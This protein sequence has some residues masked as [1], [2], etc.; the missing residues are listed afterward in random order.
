MIQY[1]VTVTS[2]WHHSDVTLASLFRHT[3]INIGIGQSVSNIE[4]F[5]LESRHPDIIACKNYFLA[6]SRLRAIEIQNWSRNY[7]VQWYKSD[8]TMMSFWC[9]C[10]IISHHYHVIRITWPAYV[11]TSNLFFHTSIWIILFNFLFWLIYG[12]VVD[13]GNRLVC[14]FM[15]KSSLLL[16]AKISFCHFLCLLR[17]CFKV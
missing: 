13:S 6:S 2:E 3:R 14:I 11:N 17:L 7:S 16:N 4:I 9:Y 12:T 15:F 8:I 1:H 10:H 5:N